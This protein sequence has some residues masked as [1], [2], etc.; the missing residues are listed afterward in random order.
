M[1]LWGKTDADNSRPKY[2]GTADLAKAIFVDA[3]EAQQAANK[4]RGLNGA[5]WWLYNSY[6]DADG[7]TR[8]KTELLVAIQEAA[9]DAG[10]RAD[11]TKASDAAY[12]ITIG[13]Q[14]A[15]QDTTAGE[16]TFS[17]AATV[18]SGGGTLAYQWQ[19]KAVGASKWSNV[20]GATSSSLALT[21]QTADNTG[22]QYRVKVT[23]AGGAK[24]VTSDVATLTFVS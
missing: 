15:N 8:Y 13:T 10:D 18:T 23:S 12:V 21:G 6:T 16:A 1:A 9:A 7:N 5:G 19:K 22:D 2:L 14:P 20:A 17:V 24:E 3:T 11:D 4:A